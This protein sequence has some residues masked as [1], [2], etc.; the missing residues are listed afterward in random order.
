[1]YRL[2]R[3]H[4]SPNRNATMT[5]KCEYVNDSCVVFQYGTDLG[6]ELAID[7]REIDDNVNEIGIILLFRVSFA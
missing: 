1:M 5:W 7:K 4:I 6:L 3:C 2:L